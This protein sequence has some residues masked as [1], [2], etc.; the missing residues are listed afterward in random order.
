MRI[1]LKR[2]H[3]LGLM[4]LILAFSALACRASSAPNL[5]HGSPSGSPRLILQRLSVAFLGQDGHTVIGSG[6]PGDFG[7]GTLVNYHLI[8]GGV[9][10]S[11]QIQ[12]ILV[13]GDNSTLTTSSVG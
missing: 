2:N 13:A 1:L 7:K 11:K 4:W 9:D 6:C 3:F 12:R 5:N 10:E 8:V